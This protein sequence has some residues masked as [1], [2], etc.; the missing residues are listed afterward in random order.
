MIEQGESRRLL[1]EIKQYVAGGESSYQRIKSGREL[2]IERGEGALMWDVDG[3]RLID[4]CQGF[5]ALLLGHAPK[6]V[7]ERVV[8]EISTVGPHHAF[9]HRNYVTVGRAITELVPK[10]ELLR[11][12]N[13]GTEAT[14]AAMRLARAWRGREVIVRF[15]GHYHGWSDVHYLGYSAGEGTRRLPDSPGIP[16]NNRD[17]LLVVPWNDAEAL[18]DVFA[19]HGRQIAAVICEAVM[20]SAGA[21][22]P[23]PGFLRAIR[24][25]TAAH[26]ALF[27][28][29]EVMTGFR[30]APGGATELFRAEP[31][32]VTL[33]KALGS[34]YPVA[35]FG[36]RRD[37][38]ALEADNVVMHGGTYTGSPLSLAAAAA[39][40]EIVTAESPGMYEDLRLRSRTLRDGVERAGRDAGIPI[41]SFGE[42]AMFQF[43]F[44]DQDVEVSDLKSA[45]AAQDGERF[46]AFTDALLAEGVYVHAYPMGRWFVSTEHTPEIVE[47]T[48][49]ASARA[50]ERMR[51]A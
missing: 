13:S 45:L 34:G 15:E 12:A 7:T 19:V 47:E 28:L 24:E 33:A 3:N 17:N 37:V 31:D 43:F 4:Y 2:C 39:V 26:D 16:I 20:G 40:L 46:V 8:A 14:M 30:V 27:I 35:A 44:G 5:G 10:V 51:I 41:R 42:G 38:M 21:I 50:F 23:Q 1:A 25:I 29:D 32:I 9:P 22:R 18:R 49:E 36:G 11:F 48:I 6:A